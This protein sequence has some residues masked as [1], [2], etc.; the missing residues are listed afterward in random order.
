MT[1]R[2]QKI[3]DYLRPKILNKPSIVESFQK[4]SWDDRN[5]SFL[6]D[7][8]VQT[9]NFDKLTSRLVGRYRR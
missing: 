5:G 7:S 3:I 2:E 9:I 1:S 8:N 4:C 6:V